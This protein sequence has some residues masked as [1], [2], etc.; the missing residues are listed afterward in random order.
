[1]E[2]IPSRRSHREASRAS[3]ASSDSSDSSDIRVSKPNNASVNSPSIVSAPPAA[4]EPGPLGLNVVYT[5]DCGHKVDIVFIHGLGGTSR[6]TWSKN[7]DPQ[8]FW[9]LTFLSLEPDLCSARILTFGYDASFAKPTNVVTSILDFAKDLLFDLKYAKNPNLDDLDMGKVPL[10]FVAHSMGGLIVKEAYLQGQHNPEYEAIIKAVSAITFLA[11]PHRGTNLAQTLNRI[12]DT[13]VLTN[14]KQ[15][16]ADLVKNSPTLQKLNE[17]FRHIAPRLDIVSFYETQPTSIGI[18][19]AR[20]RL[21]FL[22]TQEEVSKALNADHHGVCKYDD[23]RDPNYIS[24]RNILKSLMNKADRRS[25]LRLKSL[26]ALPELPSTDYIFYRDLWT[27]DTCQWIIREPTFAEWRESVDRQPHSVLSSFVVNRL[28][29]DGCQCQY[30]FIRFGDQLKRTISLLLRSLAFQSV[31]TLPGVVEKITNL[32]DEALEFKSADY[33]LI[34]DRIFKSFIFMSLPSSPIYWVIDGLDESEDPQALVKFLRDIPPSTPLRLF[35]TSRH[36]SEIDMAFGRNPESLRLSTLNSQGHVDDLRRHIRAELRIHAK[37]EFLEDV[38]KRIIEGSRNNFLWVRL[39]VEKVN[40]CHISTDVHS[41]LHDFPVGMEALYNRMA[42]AVAALPSKRSRALAIRVIQSTAWGFVVPDKDGNVVMIHK[43]ARDYL[44]DGDDTERPL[45]IDRQE[46]H[47]QILLDGLRCLMSNSLRSD[48]ANGQPLSFARYAAEFWPV[49]LAQTAQE[50]EECSVALKRF[51]TGRWSLTWI[52]LL[53]SSG[54]L[55][56]MIQASRHL[57]RYASRRGKESDEANILD[58]EF[59]ENWAMDMLRIPPKFG[60]ALHRKP[61]S[62]YTLIPPFCPRSSPVYQQFARKDGLIVKGPSRDKWDDS[63]ARM[64]TGKEMTSAVDAVGSV[65]VVLTDSGALQFYDS[66]DFRQLPQSPLEHDETVTTMHV[67][68]T[69]TLAATYGYH[70][71]KVWDVQSGKCLVSIAHSDSYVQS[72]SMQFSEDNSVLLVATDDRCIRS[73]NLNDKEPTWRPVARLDE[74]E[75]EGQFANSPSQMCLSR[76][77]S[78]VAVKELR[79]HPHLPEVFGLNLEGTL[80]RW[81]PYEDRTEEVSTGAMKFCVSKDGER[82]ATGD[83]RGR[84]RI[85]TAENFT[86]LYQLTSQDTVLG[87]S[88]SPDS[89]RLYDIRGYHANAWE[90][91]SLAKFKAFTGTNM[92]PP[93]VYGGSLSADVS[94]ASLGAVDPIASLSTSPSSHYVCSGTTYGALRLHDVR[95]AS[96]ETLWTSPAKFPVEGIVWNTDGSFLCFT[97]ASR[98]ITLASVTSAE[99]DLHWEI[100]ATIDMREHVKGPISHLLFRPDS[101]RLLVC[102]ASQIHIVSLETFTVERSSDL[103]DVAMDG[104]A[105]HPKGETLILGYGAQDLVVYNWDLSQ[106]SRCHFTYRAEISEGLRFSKLLPAQDKEHL[107]LQMEHPRKDIQPQF[108]FLKTDG[109][110]TSSSSPHSTEPWHPGAIGLRPLNPDTSSQILNALVFL[111]GNRLVYLSKNLSICSTRISWTG[112]EEEGKK[113]PASEPVIS[114]QGLVPVGRRH[115]RGS[116]EEAQELF[117]LP[118]DWISQDSLALCDVM[119]GERTFVCP[120]NGEVS[121]VKCA[122]LL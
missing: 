30:F 12:L 53:A 5:P 4:T 101:G 88:F 68:R 114:R 70:T 44:L 24:V 90:P 18:K 25:Y 69:A 62:I 84:I 2:P 50:D 89:R 72:L 102:T 91:A 122:A 49:H 76:D 108:Y 113:Q 119:V 52:H 26:L 21:R 32:A 6:W 63:V 79:W 37:A 104:W 111:R 117:A 121:M 106:V 100:R 19:S 74:E 115:S 92:D 94:F 45:R 23:P 42:S 75:V 96:A 27:Q 56:T 87:L 31:H 66:T 83:R 110:P 28:V 7:R 97:D 82:L 47:K 95:S 57:S 60:H 118:G 103:V 20:L 1:M 120:R 99:A 29:E 65:V 13:T 11:T 41:V 54:Q 93:S 8:L 43:T 67:N 51:L 34:W 46:A 36:T 39:A 59:L 105:Q 48:L 107:L 71:L 16:V 17:Q 58:V 10:I 80:F 9:P 22:D 35:L 61:D 98:R 64:S 55:H 33:R 14:S 109:I 116:P 112:E 85:Y 15:Y 40:Q 38:E 3:R 86:L 77:G 73:V 78:R 81:A